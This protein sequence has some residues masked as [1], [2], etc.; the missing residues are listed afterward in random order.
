M[1]QQKKK[2]NM[3]SLKKKLVDLINLTKTMKVDGDIKPC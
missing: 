3:N 1:K 2:L